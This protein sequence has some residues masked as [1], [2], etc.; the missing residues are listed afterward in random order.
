LAQNRSVAT[1]KTLAYS[2]HEVARILGEIRVVEEELIPVFEDMIQDA[3]IVQLGIMKHLAV[4]LS[5]LP[6][7]SCLSYLPLI[8]DILYST[9][10]FNWRFRQCIAVQLPEVSRRVML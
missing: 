6:Q 10:P 9:N 8:H 2:L 3:E 4:F 1:K 5:M 7:P